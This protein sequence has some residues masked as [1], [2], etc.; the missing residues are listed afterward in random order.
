MYNWVPYECGNA[1]KAC[2]DGFVPH[3]RAVGRVFAAGLALRY[4]LGGQIYLLKTFALTMAG[5][6]STQRL[7]GWR[8]RIRNGRQ[9]LGVDKL[10]YGDK[11]YNKLI[12]KQ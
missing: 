5:V 7:L 8:C 4:S 1:K 12:L 2:F 9:V 3:T 10:G 6:L 11:I